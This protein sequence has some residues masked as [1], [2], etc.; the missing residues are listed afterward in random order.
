MSRPLLL[1]KDLFTEVNSENSVNSDNSDNSENSLG[2][3][4]QVLVEV[5]SDGTLKLHLDRKVK[6]DDYYN[7]FVANFYNYCHLWIKSN[8]EY[9]IDVNIFLQFGKCLNCEDHEQLYS[10]IK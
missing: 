1:I 3:L 8:S 7:I 4:N 10:A 6:N 5:E 2:W 9:K